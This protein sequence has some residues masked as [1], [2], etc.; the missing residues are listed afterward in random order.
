MDWSWVSNDGH[1]T[2]L[3]I[4]TR[5]F[6][7]TSFTDD[8]FTM[9]DSNKTIR[10]WVPIDGNETSTDTYAQLFRSTTFANE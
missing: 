2:S 4:H 3:D 9:M 7:S 6:L 10:L 8:T 5:L 1:E